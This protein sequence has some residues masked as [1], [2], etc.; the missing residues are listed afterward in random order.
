[1]CWTADK[2]AHYRIGYKFGQYGSIVGFLIIALI[3]A[4]GKEIYDALGNG[5]PELNDYKAGVIGAW[6]GMWFKTHEFKK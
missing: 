4:L 6:D 3:L 1:M 2:I 5:T